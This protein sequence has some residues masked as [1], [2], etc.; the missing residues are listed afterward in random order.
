MHLKPT[1]LIQ[2]P[3]F[4]DHDGSVDD[5]VALI[6][7]LTLPQ[8]RLTGVSI[9]NANCYAENAVESTLRILDLFCRK[10]VEVAISNEEPINGFPEE[11]R[12]NK[13][14]VN[15]ID[16]LAKSKFD[17]SKINSKEAADFTAEKIL[18]EEEKTIVILT[19]PAS[20]LAKTIEKYP[21]V[22]SK[23]DKILWM[24]GAFL[25]D[26]NVKSPDHDGSAEWNIFW[27]PNA[28]SALLNS[29]IPIFLFPLDTCKQLPVDNYFMFHLKESEKELSHLVHQLFD[30]LYSTHKRYYMWDVSPTVYLG[31]PELFQFE[32]TAIDVELRGTSR[33]NI[34]R[35]S[36]GYKV[37]YSKYVNDEGFYDFLLEQ[38]QQF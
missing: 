25:V 31:Q 1:N 22:I 19:G 16:S 21:E 29:G 26:G 23:I 28:A 11:W 14:F 27:N 36:K 32:N 20:N 9:T 37:K 35:T 33:G 6:N 18:A 5:F 2:K 8:Y 38:F 10:D 24:A 17:S 4:H 7:L 13:E 3:V 34:Y 12:R 30:P 15:S